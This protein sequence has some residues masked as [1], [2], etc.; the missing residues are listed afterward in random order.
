M[1]SR[2][3]RALLAP[4]LLAVLGTPA[5]ETAT[6]GDTWEPVAETAAGRIYHR[7][8]TDSQVPEAMIITRFAAPPAQVHAV[9]TDYNRFADFIPHV[10]ESRILRTA[11]GI[12]WVYHHLRFPGPVADRAY[13]IRSSDTHD[14]APEDYFHVAWQ[15]SER[16]FPDVDLSAGLRPERFS[17]FWELRPLEGTSQTIARYGVHS[18]P[19]GWIPAWLVSRMTDRYLQ[20]VVQAVRERLASLARNDVRR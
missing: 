8:V 15:L 20:Q 10:G 2:R 3:G 4:V 16:D 6:P 17:G 12:Q 9:V 1:F 5:A 7:A 18:D 13:I 19:G 11:G 14:D